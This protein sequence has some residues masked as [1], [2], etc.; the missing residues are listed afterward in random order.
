MA[1]FDDDSPEGSE[2]SPFVLPLVTAGVALA[3]GAGLGGIVTFFLTMKEP[4]RV[5]VPRDL[6]EA[7]L[8][9]ACA[10]LIA[11]AM[12]QLDD[13]QEKVEDLA[14][15][16]NAKQAR[17]DELE[18]EMKKRAQRGAEIVRELEAARAELKELRAQLEQAIEEKEQLV[19]E[20]KEKVEELEATKVELRKTKENLEVAKEDALKNKWKAFVGNTQL[21][22]CEKG[23]RGVT[24]SGRKKMAK[25]RN[26]VLDALD[27]EVLDRFRHCVRSEQAIPKA[28][29]AD[30]DLAKGSK[31]LPEYST[32][33]DQKNRFT[34]D[35][36]VLYCD[37]TLPEKSVWDEDWKLEDVQKELREDES[38]DDVGGDDEELG[39]PGGL[40]LDELDGLDD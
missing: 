19:E 31:P 35:F 40:N 24:L 37:P 6:T 33:I 30:K 22:V 17:V 9:A 5:E 38:K 15:Q 25:C 20:L 39:K 29:E 4:E 10:P 11:D 3:V 21:D 34:K 32:W 1:E 16:V 28:F 27:A 14:S 2:P 23:M 26:G 13:A 8:Q 18:S 12:S 7:E 36:Y